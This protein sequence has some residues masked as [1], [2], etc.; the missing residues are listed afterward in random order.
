MA[1]PRP[2]DKCPESAGRMRFAIRN[3]AKLALIATAGYIKVSA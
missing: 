1:N 3:E 2:I